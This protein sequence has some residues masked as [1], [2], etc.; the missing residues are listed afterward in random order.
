MATVTNYY[1]QTFSASSYASVSRQ[2]V[3]ES[4][5]TI[6]AGAGTN[7]LSPIAVT[8]LSASSTTNQFANLY[9]SIIVFDT[10]A[11]PSNATITS[12]TL[13]GNA[14][15]GFL[16]T[17]NLGSTSIE[18]VSS[19]PSNPA[20]IAAADYSTLG[21]TSYGSIDYA[22]FTDNAVNTISL[23]ASGI[24]N[25]TK[26]GTSKFGLRLGWDQSGTFGGSWSSTAFTQLVFC[27]GVPTLTVN[28]TVDFPTL[29]FNN[30]SSLANVTTIT[31]S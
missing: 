25:I 11:I 4:F 23:N 18:L 21:S 1:S 22:S 17:N 7:V 19:N 9:R 15:S 13:S 2:S 14:N 31:T 5:S 30:I 26:T 28:W 29:S 27:G 6:R 8:Y 16:K 10:S 3:N 20:S 24:L 12:A